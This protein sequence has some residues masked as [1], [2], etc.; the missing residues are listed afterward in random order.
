MTEEENEKRLEHL[1]EAIKGKPISKDHK[2]SISKHNSGEGNSQAKLTEDAVIL[3]KYE[4]ENSDKTHQELADQFDISR[5]GISA[6]SRGERW[7]DTNYSTIND[8]VEA[9]EGYISL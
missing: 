4:L 3:I 2:K 5:S 6:I 7:T 9:L 8:A 1:R